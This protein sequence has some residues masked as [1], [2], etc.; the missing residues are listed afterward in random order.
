VGIA[1]EEERLAGAVA[2]AMWEPAYPRLQP[3]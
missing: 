2:D 1:I 3:Y